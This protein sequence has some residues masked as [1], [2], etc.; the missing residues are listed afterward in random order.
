MSKYKIGTAGWFYKDWVNIFYPPENKNEKTDW[1]EFYSKYFNVVEVNSTYYSLPSI[2]IV[3]GWIKKVEKEEDFS[4]ILKLHQNFTHQRNY[5][6]DNVNAFQSSLNLLKRENRL[7]GL[8]IQ[9]PYTFQFSDEAL[10][11]ISSLKEIFDNTNLF[12]E[13]RHSSWLNKN[14]I[15]YFAEMQLTFCTIDQPQFGRTIPFKPII[16][17]A[18]AYIRFHGRNKEAWSDSIKN[19]GKRQTYE[20]QSERYK[21]LYSKTEILEIVFQI[22][23][24]ENKVK[25]IYLIMN[26]HPTGYAVANAF[27]FIH[28][29]KENMKLK[30]PETLVKAFPRLEEIVSS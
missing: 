18:L 6:E 11:Y 30:P 25:E 19:F 22:K 20:E 10:S 24:I 21:Y 26:N 15:D 4:F 9:F 7:S 17:N 16:T 5:T 27:E 29:L 28:H 23:E 12:F 1:L 2:P 13:L 8:L 14:A 3:N